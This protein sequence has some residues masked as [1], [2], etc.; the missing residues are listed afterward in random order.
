MRLNDEEK[1]NC[2]KDE[3]RALNPG[4]DVQEQK[5]VPTS[6]RYDVKRCAATAHHDVTDLSV[7]TL[8][9]DDSKCRENSK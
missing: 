1:D 2:E 8:A 7:I 6:K 9:G 3:T 5:D 4:Q